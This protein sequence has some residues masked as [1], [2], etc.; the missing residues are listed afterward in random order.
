MKHQPLTKEKRLETVNA[1]RPETVAEVARTR[2]LVNAAW[3]EM[4]GNW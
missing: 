3:K 2:A 4:K 1:F